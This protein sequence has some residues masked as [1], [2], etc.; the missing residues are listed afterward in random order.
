MNDVVPWWHSH[1][2]QEDDHKQSEVQKKQRYIWLQEKPT[3]NKVK[4]F[5]TNVGPLC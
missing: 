4:I 1:D 5:I 2:R 3:Q